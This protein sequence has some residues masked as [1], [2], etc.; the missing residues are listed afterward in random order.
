MS[1]NSSSNLLIELDD[2]ASESAIEETVRG[3]EIDLI[4]SLSKGNNSTEHKEI[5]SVILSE[6]LELLWNFLF[7]PGSNDYLD[8][9]MANKA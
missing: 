6:T 1:K 7:G 8:Q 3:P 9:A 5:M 4:V 2:I